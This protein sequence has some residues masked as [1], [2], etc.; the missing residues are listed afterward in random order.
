MAEPNVI[1]VAEAALRLGVTPGRIRQLLDS[2]ELGSVAFRGKLRL[3][4]ESSL[5]RLIAERETKKLGKK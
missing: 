3:V 1:P 2:G 5:R 4:T